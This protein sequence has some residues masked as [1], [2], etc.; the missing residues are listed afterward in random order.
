MT[1]LQ[2]DLRAMYAEAEE[3]WR[4]R[5]LHNAVIKLQCLEQIILCHEELDEKIGDSAELIHEIDG[6]QEEMG[7]SL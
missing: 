2:S 5:T 1:K 7:E 4:K 3:G 6:E